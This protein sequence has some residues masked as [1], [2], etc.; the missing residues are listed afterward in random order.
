M[1]PEFEEVPDRSRSLALP[2][3]GQ[4]LLYHE[5]PVA[6]SS[7]LTVNFR[8]VVIRHLQKMLKVAAGHK[9]TDACSSFRGPLGQPWYSPPAP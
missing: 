1:D 6:V 5:A 2:V 4:D 9:T 3:I 8:G 7:A